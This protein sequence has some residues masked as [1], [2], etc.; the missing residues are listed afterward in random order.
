MTM[1]SKLAD[2]L[3]T[4]VPEDETILGAF[5]GKR[6]PDINIALIVVAIF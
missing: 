1:D 6:G 3:E 4:I 2:A 5:V